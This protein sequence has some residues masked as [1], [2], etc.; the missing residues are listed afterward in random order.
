MTSRSLFIRL[1]FLLVAI[2]VVHWVATYFYWYWTIPW[3]DKFPH[4]SGGLL[5]SLGTLWFVYL[6]GYI[7]WGF[8]QNRRF[9]LAYALAASLLIGLLWELFELEFGITT[10][11]TTNFYENNISDILMDVSGGLIGYAYFSYKLTAHV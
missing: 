8:L 3:V 4:F 10:M 9:A 2:A 1:F 7:K 11:Q 5:V 6:S